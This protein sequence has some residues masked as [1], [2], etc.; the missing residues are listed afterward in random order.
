MCDMGV[1]LFESEN[2]KGWD[3]R[4]EG[5][6]EGTRSFPREAIGSRIEREGEG[7]NRSGVPKAREDGGLYVQQ[8]VWFSKP[9]EIDGFPIP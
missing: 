9:I 3:T 1:V 2:K 5:R 8:V 4:D 7:K 6:I